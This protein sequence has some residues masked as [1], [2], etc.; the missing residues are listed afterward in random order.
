[1]EGTP[2]Q[3]AI[4]A[5]WYPDPNGEGLRYWDGGTWTEHTAPAAG[6]AP[7]AADDT[8]AAEKAAAEK[9]AAEKAAAEKAAVAATASSTAAGSTAASSKAAAGDPH[10][11]HAAAGGSDGP[12]TLEWALSVLLP[13]VPLAGLI[14][15]LYLR[16]QGPAMENPSNVAIVLSL[17]VIL[18]AVLLLR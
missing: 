7:T 5:G 4:P 6:E 1:M 9:A 18:V 17:V 12:G 13:I 10:A 2:E 8:A 14:W 15:G 16:R 3:S 11:A